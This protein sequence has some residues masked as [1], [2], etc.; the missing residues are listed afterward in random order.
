MKKCIYILGLLLLLVAPLHADIHRMGS[1]NIRVLSDKDTG[2]K[3]W[4]N[5][6]EY[7]A[8]II[9]GKEY[10]VI[11]IQEM[12][13][14][15]YNDLKLLLPDYGLEYWGRDSHLLSDVGEGVGVAW[16]TSRYTL[17]DKGRFFLS[18]DPEKPVISWDAASRRVSVWVK[19]QD[20]QT[21]EIFYYCSTHLDN[22]G[23]IARRQ[24]TLI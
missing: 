10:D 5:R 16:R 6:K 14:V 15:Q 17:L 11:G 3:A 9:T 2:D 22:A 20:K 12:K 1:Y 7:V 18:E 23:T 21:D 24:P 13:K 4:T 8:R 19:L